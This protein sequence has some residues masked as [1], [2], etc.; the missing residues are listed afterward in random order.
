MPP[1]ADNTDSN[2]PPAARGRQLVGAACDECRRRKLRCDGKQPQCGICQDTEVVC[3]TTQRSV[4]GPKRGHLKALKNRIVQ[5]EAMLESSFSPDQQPDLLHDSRNCHDKT[6]GSSL[7]LSNVRNAVHPS[8]AWVPTTA[9]SSGPEQGLFVSDADWLQPNLAIHLNDLGLTNQ[10]FSFNSTFPSSNLHLTE[11]LQAELDQLYLDRVHQSIPIIHRRRY[12]SWSKSSTNPPFRKCLQYAM[13]T[14]ASLMS[15]HSRDLAEPL[16]QQTKKMLE[17]LSPEANE[18]SSFN[19]TLAQAWVLVVTFESIRTHHRQAWMSVGRAFRLVQGMRYHEIDRP[20]DKHHSS[21]ALCRDFI[22]AEE[23]RRV[24]WMTYF[25]D[26]I[27][28]MRN[29]WPITLNEHVVS[30]VF[31]D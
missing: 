22:E 7:R 31:Q 5:L 18:N 14:L 11:V 20:T 28:S 3:E 4:R 1:G 19:T 30:A 23:M 15:V 8:E 24:F 25:L 9:V 10:G 6:L 17:D 12:L 2:R 26:H 27:I 13:W 29:D 16:Y 21:P